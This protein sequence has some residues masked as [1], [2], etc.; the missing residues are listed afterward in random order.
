M[1]EK[2]E[3]KL[4]SKSLFG[5]SEN[6][7]ESVGV[8]LLGVG[9]QLYSILTGRRRRNSRIYVEQEEE[10]AQ[11]S[12]KEKGLEIRRQSKSSSFRGSFTGSI[13]RS[14]SVD[15]MNSRD[16]LLIDN[17]SILDS[18][19]SGTKR[20]DNVYARNIPFDSIVGIK[21]CIDKGKALPVSSTITRVTVSVASP[22]GTPLEGTFSK[23]FSD[24]TSHHQFPSFQW[25]T[26]LDS[27]FT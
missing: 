16:L 25:S 6:V 13:I 2:N 22:D 3:Q 27:K 19:I 4:L 9:S 8:R 10:A 15:R 18:S 17:A 24:P 14:S 11:T 21:L 26:M 7:T 23:V 5:D 1:N 20:R 12:P